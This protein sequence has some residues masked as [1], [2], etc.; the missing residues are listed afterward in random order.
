V[1]EVD[2]AGITLLDLK[3]EIAAKR[4]ISPSVSDRSV[5]RAEAQEAIRIL[6]ERAVVLSEGKRLGVSLSGSEIEKEVARFR[7]DFPPGGLEKAIL[8]AGSDMESWREELARSLL[9][10]K[11]AAAIA[12]SRAS[13]SPEEVEAIYRKRSKEFSRPERIRVRQF[14]FDAEDDA[15]EA[16][17]R[18]MEWENPDKAIEKFSTGDIRAVEADLGEITRDDVPDEIADELFSLKEGGVSG[19]VLREGNYSLFLVVGKEPAV[20]LSLAAAAPGIREELLGSRREESFR[21]WL[22]ARVGKA[23]IRVQETLLERLTEGGK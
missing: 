12:D 14:L 6:I 22:R 23:D 3:R 11:S 18:I 4:G 13:V 8:Q 9:Y 15:R 5:G 20:N 16:R 21:S 7:A 10:R 2:G 19:V 17:R 1:A